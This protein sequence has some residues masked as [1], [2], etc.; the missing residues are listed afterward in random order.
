M[1]SGVYRSNEEDED[2]DEDE[3]LPEDAHW[4]ADPGPSRE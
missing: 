3:K 4:R 2:Y 1:F